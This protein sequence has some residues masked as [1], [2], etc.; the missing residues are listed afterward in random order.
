MRKP[1]TVEDADALVRGAPD[2]RDVAHQGFGLFQTRTIRYRSESFSNGNVQG[3]SPNTAEITNIALSEG[4]F[5]TEADDLRR[6]MVCVIGTNVVEALFPFQQTI[7]GKVIKMAGHR[8]R[9]I[10]VLEKRKNTFFG[11]NDEDNIIQIPY[12]TLRKL[13]PSNDSL[14][15]VIRAKPGR[16][17]Q[18]WDQAES[19]LRRQRGVRWNQDNNF[20]L[21]TADRMIKQFDSITATIG[22]VAIAISGVGLLVGGIGV[23]NIMLVSVT[24]RTREIGVRKAVGARRSDI[25]VQFLFE[26][27]TLTT[28]GGLV[29]LILA[30]GI[31]YLLILLFPSIPADI[32]LW[33]VVTGL[34]VSISVGLVFGVWPAVK[35][36][37]L[38]PIESLRWE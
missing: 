27:M 5:I 22:L 28:V 20:D 8:F 18:A 32:P 29:G 23:M 15:L 12:R 25:I 17:L 14:L 1:L 4:R 38:D 9:V 6:S 7:A 33:A 31:S 11:E 26:A 19:V 21:N 36:A 30:V 34:V 13:M 16:L 2:I 10:G 35:A 37:K 24:E 3:V